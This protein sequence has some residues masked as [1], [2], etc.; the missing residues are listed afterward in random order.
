MTRAFRSPLAGARTKGKQRTR[1]VNYGTC[2]AAN[3]AATPL[4]PQSELERLILTLRTLKQALKYAQ[5]DQ[6]RPLDNVTN[7]W[8][9]QGQKAAADLFGKVSAPSV[10]SST[11][12]VASWGWDDA[13]AKGEPTADQEQEQDGE[14]DAEQPQETWTM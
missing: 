6:Q 9:S 5:E 4:D 12:T 3:L 14:L 7:L 10:E 11:P 13:P 2:G 8:L 1:N